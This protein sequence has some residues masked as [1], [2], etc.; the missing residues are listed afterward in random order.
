MQRPCRR[1]RHAQLRAVNVKLTMSFG[2]LRS[3]VRKAWSDQAA[4]V[5][6][7]RPMTG[8]ASTRSGRPARGGVGSSGAGDVC[9]RANPDNCATA[10]VT[11]TALP[12]NVQATDDNAETIRHRMEVYTEA[13]DPLLATYRDRGLLVEVDGIGTIDEV[14]ARITAALDAKLG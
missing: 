8:A 13:T 2:V 1:R 5:L 11:V 10:I 9:E 3:A 6:H 7:R 14:S 12:N 4:G